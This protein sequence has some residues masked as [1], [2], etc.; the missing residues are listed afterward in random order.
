MPTYNDLLHSYQRELEE[1]GIPAATLRLFLYELTQERDIDLYREID[2]EVP[3]EL[4]LRFQSGMERILREEPL[5]YVLG[6]RWFYGYR[7][8]V[9][10]DVLIPRD[11]TEELAA[12]ILSVLDTEYIGREVKA[13]DVGCGSGAI[14]LTI[15]KEIPAVDMTLTDIS[16]E[17]LKVAEMN[18]E[19][20]DCGVRF[21]CGDMLEPLKE[22]G[23]KLD[24]L[25]S[26]PPYIPREE[27][28][29][30]SVK[31]YEPHVALFGGSDGLY[32]YRVL[33][34]GAREVMKEHGHIFFEIGWNQK[35]SLLKLAGQYFP[36]GR[37]EV[38]RD[39]N[40][41]DRMFQLRF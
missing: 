18:A 23:I 33:L 9:N 1:K 19:A 5:A 37:A 21:L 35:E 24:I 40:G 31:D 11:E 36:E 30:A 6:Y 29:E 39:I 16:P 17:A 38:F 25:V 26:N 20:L 7:F 13:A 15:K 2:R 8:L 27:A 28:L 3:E 4:R 32:F 12:L 34:S 41:K 22:E 14:G 10:R